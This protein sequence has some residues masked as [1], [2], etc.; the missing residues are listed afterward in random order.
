MCVHSDAGSLVR[1]QFATGL[2]SSA[3]SVHPGLTF[4]DRNGLGQ[5]VSGDAVFIHH[6]VAGSFG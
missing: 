6:R 2:V 5:V 1:Q 3:N 4:E